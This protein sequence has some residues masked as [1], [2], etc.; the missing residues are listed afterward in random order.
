MAGA[1][2]ALLLLAGESAALLL[3]ARESISL[4]LLAG[5]SISLL[6]LAESFLFHKFRSERGL[7][8]VKQVLHKI[9]RKGNSLN[10]RKS[11]KKL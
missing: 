8:S 9:G 5:E 1:S 7:Q 2:I 4:L 10:R 6:L 3:L 11:I